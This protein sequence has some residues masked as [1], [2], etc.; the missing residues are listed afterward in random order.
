[1][2][3]IDKNGDPKGAGR[4]KKPVL[5]VI[6]GGARSG[7]SSAA[8]M[9][10][11]SRHREAVVL[12][13]AHA[14]GDAEMS[15]RIARHRGDRPERFRTLEVHEGMSWTVDVPEDACL[16]LDCLGTLVA[17]MVGAAFGLHGETASADGV[18]SAETE[19]TV[20]SSVDALVDW[21]LARE[22]DT[23]IVTNE[24]GSGIVPMHP[25]ARL[26][27]DV[28]GRANRKLAD[29]ADAAY[30]ACAGR[31]LDLTAMPRDA[32]WPERG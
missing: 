11:A 9:L 29:A 6:T 1:M 13:A 4:T 16:L 12:V 27:R 22:G 14:E 25:D 31:L 10:V 30:L 7:K 17:Q 2:S 18:V 15:R 8:Q 21:L 5:I 3:A 32:A 23:V 20:E 26:F 28:L 24:V 19:Q